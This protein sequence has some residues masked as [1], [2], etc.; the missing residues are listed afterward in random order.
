MPGGAPPPRPRRFLIPPNKFEKNP[1]PPGPVPSGT[2]TTLTARGLDSETGAPFCFRPQLS[3]S[4]CHKPPPTPGPCEALNPGPLGSGLTSVPPAV[5]LR[6]FVIHQ[7]FDASFRSMSHLTRSRSSTTK[8][9]IDLVVSSMF[10]A[11]SGQWTLLRS[12]TQAVVSAPTEVAIFPI[13]SLIFGEFVFNQSPN[14]CI[15]S[16]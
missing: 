13:A 16:V 9:A 11:T 8:P 4:H 2:L 7:L 10:F 14:F 15:G 6:N 12:S 1:P 5:L 3:L